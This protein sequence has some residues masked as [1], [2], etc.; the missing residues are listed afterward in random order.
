MDAGGGHGRPRWAV[1][2][3]VRCLLVER[4][5]SAANFYFCDS[6]ASCG[7]QQLQT[8]KVHPASLAGQVGS[9]QSLPGVNEAAYSPVATHWRASP[10]RFRNNVVSLQDIATFMQTLLNNNPFGTGW[11]VPY[12]DFGARK[13]KQV[14]AITRKQLAFIVANV[15]MGNSVP[16]SD[17]LS[18]AL[19]SC[20]SHKPPPGGIVYSLLSFLAV[21]SQ[22]DRY[23]PGSLDTM[24][25]GA[26]PG[27]QTDEWKDSLDQVSL[28]QPTVCNPMTGQECGLA[29]FMAGGVPY[30]A[31]T[32]IAGGIVGGGA[33][34]CD[35]ANTQD[36]SLVQFWS[37]TL[38][39]AFFSGH[40]GNLPTPWVLMGARRYMG[41]LEGESSA[42]APYFGKCG[43]ITSVDWL[44]QDIPVDSA[45]VMVAGTSVHLHPG[46]FVAVASTCAACRANGKC[47]VQDL[48]SN[49]CSLQREALDQDISLWFQ[50]YSPSMYNSAVRTAF[51]SVVQRIGTGPWGAGAWMGDSQW[52]FLGVWVATALVGGPT[53]DYYV[54]DRF[55]ENA[56]NQCYVMSE[57]ACKS[58]IRKSLTG[59]SIPESSCG[60]SSMNDMVERFSGQTPYALYT[61]LQNVGDP[62]TQVFDLISRT[63]NPPTTPA[64]P[65]TTTTTGTEPATP[66]PLPPALYPNGQPRPS[67]VG[68]S[69]GVAA[70]A[71]GLALVIG[72]AAIAAI[73]A[74]RL[75]GLGGQPAVVQ[76]QQRPFIRDSREEELRQLVNV[77][78][79]AAAV[80]QRAD[81]RGSVKHVTSE[82]PQLQQAP[83]Q[84]GPPQVVVRR[85]SLVLTQGVAVAPGHYV[86]SP[87]PLGSV[88]TTSQTVVLPERRM[89]PGP[90]PFWCTAPE[91]SP[92]GH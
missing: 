57:D 71:A 10:P 24:V 88:V 27:G 46:A 28:D 74:L 72:L 22:E 51:R 62:P 63:K 84:H 38:A 9:L 80:H 49:S 34:L 81:S 89:A 17:G 75:L 90:G 3:L 42:G 5:S 65:S 7:A 13:G 59:G 32:D 30:Q 35:V 86:G 61:M 25:I 92:S 39:F 53:L 4:A 44:N 56:G 70:A 43:T 41:N 85:P 21:L 26:T 23:M 47:S 37:E 50:A 29:D 14:V 31:M 55:C 36:E 67:S 16:I 45:T 66:W 20:T 11:S 19:E 64:T 77:A 6:A 15:L 12:V 18:H 79:S 54:Y 82:P 48:M 40:N 52:Y 60:K 76:V 68:S 83:V 91:M 73:E 69:L 33:G 2:A 87:L 8:W 78:S 1:L 58:C